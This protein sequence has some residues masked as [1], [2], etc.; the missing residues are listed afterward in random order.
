MNS[1]EY[2]RRARVI[3]SSDTSVRL[4]WSAISSV[5]RVNACTDLDMMADLFGVS[6]NFFVRSWRGLEGLGSKRG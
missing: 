1:T 2:L 5:A 4:S 3:A 6:T